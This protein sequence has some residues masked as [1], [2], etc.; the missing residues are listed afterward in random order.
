VRIFFILLISFISKACGNIL[1]VKKYPTSSGYL[2][3]GH[4]SS[5]LGG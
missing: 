3:V 1:A 2:G 4:D 5:V